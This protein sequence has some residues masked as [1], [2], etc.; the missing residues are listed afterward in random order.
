M[1]TLD[2]GLRIFF[3]SC[4][5]VNQA[6]KH[7]PSFRHLTD[8]YE[9]TNPTLWE[10]IKEVARGDKPSYSSG[11]HT[12]T[13][14][15]NWARWPNPPASAW[16]VKQYNEFG[17]TWKKK[18][19]T[20]TALR[21]FL[22]GGIVTTQTPDEEQRLQDLANKGLAFKSSVSGK[23]GIWEAGPRLI[24]AAL[25]EDLRR[26][27]Q[28][29]L[30]GPYDWQEAR[31]VGEWLDSNFRVSSPKTPP[32]GKQLKAKAQTLL[33]VLKNRVIT[34][35]P[36]GKTEEEAL[37][38]LYPDPTKRQKVLDLAQSEVRSLW[39]EIEPQL[40]QFVTGFTDE[41][42]SIVP[43]NL[44]VGGV[45]YINQA[46]LIESGL[47]TYV[48]RLDPIIGKLKGWRAK[49]AKGGL[50]VVLASPKEFR[51]TSGG[52]YKE[53]EDALYIRTTPAVLK[54]GSGYGSF[55]YILVH[56][57]GH[58][59]EKLYGRG[60]DFDRPEWWT[61]PYSRKEG[62]GLSEA[63]A[64]LFALGHFG[65]KGKWDPVVDSFEKLMDGREEPR[66]PSLSP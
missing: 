62:F 49:A 40:A 42:G 33:W 38:T 44:A 7:S 5:Y 63:F 32:K 28:G 46:G 25:G 56:E 51:G 58:R 23:Y 17:G 31:R 50:K 18:G 45:T 12:V 20:R 6:A 29:I 27:M 47:K 64:E 19:A 48:S 10:R 4:S 39:G 54:R 8:E 52:K 65:L 60:Y 13:K 55:E 37:D 41:G 16:A 14:P 30:N 9:P 1:V 34:G 35:V 26:K 43:K 2:T 21:I 57:L 11:G 36:M 24:R 61:T 53:S 66:K 22:A 15:S 59:Y 3:H